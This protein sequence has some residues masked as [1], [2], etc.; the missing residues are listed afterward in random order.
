M[1]S[2]SP[3]IYV[4]LV[5]GVLLVVLAILQIAGVPLPS[6]PSSDYPTD[7]IE[8]VPVP[9]EPEPSYVYKGLSREQSVCKTLEAFYKKG[10]PTTRPAWLR[11]PA[12]G[13]LL[14]YDCYNEELKIAAEHNGEHHYVYPNKFHASEDEFL[15]QRKRDETKR[16]LSD[17]NG[18]YLLTVPYWVPTNVIKDWVEYYC[19]ER[20]AQRTLVE[21]LKSKNQ[22]PPVVQITSS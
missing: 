9:K 14:E 13:H 7:P 22:S 2:L 11:N 10:F 1:S 8:T 6:S 19:P 5:L 21:S 17:E 3:F 4:L 15:A 20:V 16:R 12:T 18:V